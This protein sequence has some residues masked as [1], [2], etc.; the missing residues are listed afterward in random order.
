MITNRVGAPGWPRGFQTAP[1]VLS[2]VDANERRTK[3]RMFNVLPRLIKNT[4]K[5]LTHFTCN[6]PA[7]KGPHKS[8]TMVTFPTTSAEGSPQK[9]NQSKTSSTKICER[10]RN[11]SQE[12][13]TRTRTGGPSRVLPGFFPSGSRNRFTPSVCATM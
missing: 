8:P 6:S 3:M 13:S 5:N 11:T 1:A 2:R 12:P 10:L 4:V 9:F 7:E